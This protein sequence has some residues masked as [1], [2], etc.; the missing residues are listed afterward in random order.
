MSESFLRYSDLEDALLD[1]ELSKL[2]DAL[3][4]LI[5]SLA[6]SIAREKPDGARAPNEVLSKALTEADLRDLAPSRVDRHRLGDIAEA[7]IAFAWLR[8]EIGV[9]E[10]AKIL[11]R[12][13]AE[14]DFQSRQDIFKG[15]EK[16][17]KNLLVT[18]SERIPL[19]KS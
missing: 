1:E 14:R 16:G 18:I 8:D 12:P 10:A 9:E 13:L 17:F 3:V 4:N 19:E 5:Y 7:I 11:S 6:R 15:A 2:G